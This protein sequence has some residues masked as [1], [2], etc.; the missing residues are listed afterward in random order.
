MDQFA[1][2]LYKVMKTNTLSP[3]FIDEFSS[4]G[5]L[6][7]DDVISKSL[8]QHLIE[9]IEFLCGQICDKL[10]ISKTEPTKYL[11]LVKADRTAAGDIFDSINKLPLVNRIFY[12][13]YFEE[14]AKQL[15]HTNV[16]LSPPTQMNL[17]SDHPVEEM[18][19]YPWHTDFSYN[20]GSENSLVFW[21]PLTDVD[22]E[23]GSL[24]VLEKSHLIHPEISVDQ[25]AIK[26]RQSAKYFQI[27]NIEQIKSTCK[28]TR[29]NLKQGQGVVFDSK[30]VHKS[31]KNTSKSTRFA[32]QLRWMDASSPDAIERHYRG[33]IDAGLNPLTY[34]PRIIDSNG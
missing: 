17:R 19:L 18:H 5:F 21:I 7:I 8:A 3:N 20:S 30:L 28:E 4:K 29:V 13:E 10:K 32:M 11:S 24:H 23:V 34:M 26:L 31:G 2:R 22:E 16:V 6:V 12:D 1:W 27:T 14:I 9:Q 25:K 33:G 15:L